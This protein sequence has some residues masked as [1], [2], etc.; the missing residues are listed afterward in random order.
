MQGMP[1]VRLQGQAGHACSMHICCRRI[2]GGVPANTVDASSVAT[3]PPA[4]LS[5][6]ATDQ[7]MVPAGAPS[8]DAGEI[9][10]MQAGQIT[11]SA[12]VFCKLYQQG[13]TQQAIAAGPR[14]GCARKGKSVLTL[15]LLLPD[16][17]TCTTCSACTEIPF[18]VMCCAPDLAL[19]HPLAFWYATAPAARSAWH[20]TML[21]T[22]ASP[23][24]PFFSFR[25]SVMRANCDA[26]L[27]CAAR[28]QGSLHTTLSW[29]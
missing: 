7:H 21:L 27:I 25:D 22:P 5:L 15:H 9:C 20:K 2:C 26:K 13:Y 4:R 17:R 6:S 19:R 18:T 3:C 12:P 1:S 16:S 23:S 10:A 28:R 8:G 14:R 24:L 29:V 11:H